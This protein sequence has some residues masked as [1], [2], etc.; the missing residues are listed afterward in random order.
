MSTT[1]K[2]DETQFQ[3]FD[4]GI[5]GISGAINRLAESIGPVEEGESLSQNVGKWLAEIQ[6][7]I[8]AGF[9]LV[10]E[11]IANGQTPPLPGPK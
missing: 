10:A 9:K 6:N 3:Q 7:E 4:Q 1:R 2:L 5:D 8:R 11:A